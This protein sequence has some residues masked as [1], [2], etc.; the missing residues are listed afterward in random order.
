MLERVR[1]T[2]REASV[3]GSPVMVRLFVSGSTAED[4]PA[5]S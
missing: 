2:V 4:G 1:W 3:I 5:M